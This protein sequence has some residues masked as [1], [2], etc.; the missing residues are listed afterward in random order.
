MWRQ[1]SSLGAVPARDGFDDCGGSPQRVAAHR[2]IDT[3]T[4]RAM[5]HC[6][7][8]RMRID[9]QRCGLSQ[10]AACVAAKLVDGAIELRPEFQTGLEQIGT[11]GA[12]FSIAS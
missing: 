9:Y 1:I 10:L 2:N 6:G 7:Q 11:C 5:F 12:E 4:L 8:M 3:R